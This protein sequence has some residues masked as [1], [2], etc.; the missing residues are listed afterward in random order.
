MNNRAIQER[1]GLQIGDN[2]QRKPKKRVN[3]K[4]GP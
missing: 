1:Y 3:M 4:Q 2:A